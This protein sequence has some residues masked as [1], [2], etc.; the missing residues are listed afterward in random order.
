MDNKDQPAFAALAFDKEGEECFVK[1][2]SKREYFIGQAIIGILSSMN[3][4]TIS[5]SQADAVAD[6]AFMIADST[7]RKLSANE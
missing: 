1:G 7:L 4:G 3:P 2:I 6:E 5:L